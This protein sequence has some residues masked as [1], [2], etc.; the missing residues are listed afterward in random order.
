MPAIFLLFEVKITNHP[1]HLLRAAT[2][3]QRKG[4]QDHTQLS[5]SGQPELRGIRALCLLLCAMPAAVIP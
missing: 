4:L 2:D 1:A 3:M 5:A